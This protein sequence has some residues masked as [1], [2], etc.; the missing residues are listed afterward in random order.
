MYVSFKGGV[1]KLPQQF[2]N[3]GGRGKD[4]MGDVSE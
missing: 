1:S 3:G 2:L 4:N